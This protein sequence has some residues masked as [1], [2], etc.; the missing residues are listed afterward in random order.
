MSSP[1]K[2]YDIEILPG[3]FRPA[4]PSMD[5]AGHI[6]KTPES[7]TV[8]PR[9][10]GVCKTK[11]EIKRVPFGGAIYVYNIES[12]LLQQRISTMGGVVAGKVD[13][14]VIY[15]ANFSDVPVKFTRGDPVAQLV[16]APAS[17]ESATV[18][19]YVGES[20]KPIVG[21]DDLI[22]KYQVKLIDLDKGGSGVE[23]ITLADNEYGVF[24]ELPD[25]VDKYN[26]VIPRVYTVPE[27][28]INV[29]TKDFMQPI[30]MWKDD[31][32]A[33]KNMDNLKGLIKGLMNVDPAFQPLLKINDGRM[34]LA[35]LDVRRYYNRETL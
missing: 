9:G 35:K 12:L 25:A 19:S 4:R 1:A 29:G 24:T 11:I 5:V 16:L 31:Y 26:D 23:T 28:I 20:V 6:V 7:F 8:L 34:P 21:E 27:Q 10:M 15:F 3:G 32:D 13:E 30:V 33:V 22:K 18:K 17:I 14:L 2:M